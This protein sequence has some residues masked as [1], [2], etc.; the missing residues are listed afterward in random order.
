MYTALVLGFIVLTVLLTSIF[1]QVEWS[2]HAKSILS[3]VISTIGGTLAFVLTKGNW[4]NILTTDLFQTVITVYGGS[5]VFYNFL[6]K[7]TV[8]E[9]KMANIGSKNNEV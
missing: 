5:Q 9:E 3:V 8:A 4:D 1:K 6:L 7:G 2:S